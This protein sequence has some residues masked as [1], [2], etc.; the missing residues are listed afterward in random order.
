MY[1]VLR[2]CCSVLF[3]DLTLLVVNTERPV[4]NK[5]AAPVHRGSAFETWFCLD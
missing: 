2:Y 4:S 3:I 5:P 1:K